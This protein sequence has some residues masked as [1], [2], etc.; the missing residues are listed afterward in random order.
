MIQG[1]ESREPARDGGGGG[2]R[3]RRTWRGSADINRHDWR[4][5]EHG[6]YHVDRGYGESWT[7]T[8]G[9]VYGPEPTEAGE[10]IGGGETE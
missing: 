4:A 7:I 2:R 1:E 8:H 5:A 6:R 9:Q 10:D 3:P